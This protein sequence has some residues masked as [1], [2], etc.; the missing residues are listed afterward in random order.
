MSTLPRS[1]SRIGGP[2]IRFGP[3][4]PRKRNATKLRTSVLVLWALIDIGHILTR[5]FVLAPPALWL[6]LQRLAGFA[7]ALSSAGSSSRTI[8][9]G[10]CLAVLPT[11]K[12]K[13]WCGKGISMSRASNIRF[14]MAL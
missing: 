4:G 1:V 9:H 8:W 12:Y 3:E 14:T 6:G 5:D 13:V 11:P 7:V 10:R 2:P